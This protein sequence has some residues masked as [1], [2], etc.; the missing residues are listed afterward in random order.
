MRRRFS[1]LLFI[2]TAFWLPMQAVAAAAMPFCRHGEAHKTVQAT[3]AAEHCHLQ[4]Q[5]PRESLPSPDDSHGMSCDDCGFCHLAAS[6]FLP[7]P[8]HVGM[9]IGLG[10]EFRLHIELAPPSYIP[11][12]PQRPPRRVA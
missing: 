3:A 5:Q 4:D 12:P 11:E 1:L 6:G 2:L 8:D 9:I 7:A 10:R